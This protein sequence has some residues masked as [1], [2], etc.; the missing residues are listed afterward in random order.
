[1]SLYVPPKDYLAAKGGN[2]KLAQLT[3][4][5]KLHLNIKYINNE[6]Y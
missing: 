1:V 5:N 2:K 4:I 6:K 3:K